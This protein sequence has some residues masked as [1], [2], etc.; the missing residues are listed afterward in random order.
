L[1]AFEEVFTMWVVLLIAFLLV[2][3]LVIL[4]GVVLRRTPQNSTAWRGVAQTSFVAGILAVVLTALAAIISFTSVLEA[5][6]LNGPL[7]VAAFL[8]IPAAL[9]SI[10]CGVIGLK[11]DEHSRAL[12]GLALSAASILAWT[13]ME[14]IVG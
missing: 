13:T 14:I 10:G 6:P 3:A 8:A 12:L 9:V 7:G 2:L 11:S 5:T 4:Y 1:F